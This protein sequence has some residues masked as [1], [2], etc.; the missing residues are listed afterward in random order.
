[1][2][3]RSIPVLALALV[4]ML[5][6]SVSPVA[7][8]A[9]TMVQPLPGTTDADALVDQM[10]RLAV[11][12]QDVV[13]LVTAGELSLKLDDIS[14]AASLFARAEKADPRNGRVK[15]GEASLFVR[16]E[17]P[18]AALRYFAQA[19]SSGYPAARFASD[20]ALAYDLIG[21][22]DRAQRDYR[23]ALKGANDSETTRRYALSL[24]I[25][26]RRE[27]AL[28]QLDPLLRRQDRAAWRARAFVLAMDGDVTGASRIA[29]T[30]MPPGMAQ[31]LQPFFERLPNLPATDRAFAVHFGEI[32][33][34]AERMADAR[35]APSMAP[36]TPEPGAPVQLAVRQVAPVEVRKDQRRNPRDPRDRRDDVQL[37]AVAPVRRA[38]SVPS[39]AVAVPRPVQ[40]RPA[41]L[42][43][44]QPQAQR[45]MRVYRY[46]PPGS[47]ISQYYTV[48]EKRT[49][50]PRVVSTP[51]SVELAAVQRLPSIPA[52]AM[53][54]PTRITP[55]PVQMTPVPMRATLVPKVA[56]PT[57]VAQPDPVALV[58]T[59]ERSAIVAAAVG[60]SSRPMIVVTPA[61]TLSIA[62][63]PVPPDSITPMVAS[64]SVVP[65]PVPLVS[66]ATPIAIASPPSDTQPTLS[67]SSTPSTTAS[68]AVVAEGALKVEVANIPKPGFTTM[69]DLPAPIIETAVPV[70]PKGVGA[71]AVLANIVANLSVPA[72]ELDVRSPTPMQKRPTRQL[73]VQDDSTHVASI[74][75]VAKPSARKGRRGVVAFEPKRRDARERIVA[76]EARVDAPTTSAERRASRHKALKEGDV[77]AEVPSGT[78][79]NRG[80]ATNS[81]VLAEA[82]S[83]TP[84]EKR[85]AGRADRKTVGDKKVAAEKALADKDAAKEKKAAKSNPERIWVQVAG[86]ASE[87]DLPKAYANVKAKAPDAFAKHGA[88]KIPL[89][90]TNRVL[91][92]PFKTDADARAF[93][94]QLAKKGVPAFTFSSDEGQ[95]VE[96]LDS[97][98]DK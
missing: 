72:R 58:A 44:A 63:V 79:R 20:R 38:P 59:Q 82:V 75:E 87:S 14:G 34:T 24:G 4:P 36:L 12:P 16:T 57:T 19:E 55:V 10:R 43:A 51:S 22:Q 17:R 81:E 5:T 66:H 94:N 95:K 27:Q 35:L 9:Q 70:A 2:K 65:V 90:A 83:L 93:V 96:R 89:R 8:A 15:A 98:S 48:P 45:R 64:A 54:V 18:G 23:L 37:A 60:P 39:S 13:A 80:R 62:P 31:G 84:V 32:R 86:G 92:G 49:V 77:T 53:P 68:M 26:G 30:M 71:D 61:Q 1:M 74:D 67:P 85:A 3:N 33:P 21:Q 28:Q 91:T 52:R 73:A 97:K 7:L 76:V 25:S 46:T 69:A 29:T 42:A 78:K 11:N 88:Y 6:G 56:A 47:L 50:P 40:A 41:A